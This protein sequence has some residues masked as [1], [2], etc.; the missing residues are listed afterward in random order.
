MKDNII[1]FQCTKCKHT[2]K[3]LY[4]P[5]YCPNCEGVLG[6]AIVPGEKKI[7]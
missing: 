2:W 7:K 3:G 4:I 6:I 1:T 5:L